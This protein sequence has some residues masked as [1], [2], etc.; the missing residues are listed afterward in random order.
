MS[1]L[2]VRIVGGVVVDVCSDDPKAARVVVIDED[3]N[4][5]TLSTEDGGTF[6]ADVYEVQ[7]ST[8]HFDA[9][10][11]VAASQGVMTNGTFEETATK[12]PG[13]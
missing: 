8:L 12:G 3:R 10:E 9:E 11:V 2:F 1:Q 4:G 7:P 6:T 13:I 5:S